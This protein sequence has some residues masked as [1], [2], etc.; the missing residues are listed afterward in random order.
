[1]KCCVISFTFACSKH[2]LFINNILL[3]RRNNE[4][5]TKSDAPFCQVLVRVITDV[6]FLFGDYHRSWHSLLFR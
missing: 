6:H 4:K 1:M 5:R 2:T 3:T